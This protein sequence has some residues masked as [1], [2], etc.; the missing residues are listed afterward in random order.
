MDLKRSSL[1][2]LLIFSLA[3]AIR[4]T[5]DLINPPSAVTDPDFWY[6]YA[7]AENSTWFHQVAGPGQPLATTYFAGLTAV[8]SDWLHYSLAMTMKLA[9]AVVDSL[10][11]VGVYL[12]AAEL[13]SRR[14]GL[15]A[16]V[17][18][19]TS[20]QT[21]QDSVLKVR[22]D[23][24]ALALLIY[25]SLLLARMSRQESAAQEEPVQTG[26]RLSKTKRLVAE[27]RAKKQGLSFESR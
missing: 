8:I 9:F 14:A 23:G 4:A 13:Y 7:A 11:A 15:L 5:I 1:D 24:L 27:A 16:G 20:A 2:L 3:L 17:A 25:A 26:K 22:H 21:L 18:Y 10:S 19:A 12:L 6:Y